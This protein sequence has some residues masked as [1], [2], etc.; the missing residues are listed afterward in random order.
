MTPHPKRS[1]CPRRS[2]FRAAALV[3]S[4]LM[5]SSC[6]AETYE[7]LLRQFIEAYRAGR[8]PDLPLAPDGDA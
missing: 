1:R 6:V 4:V 8:V 2:A 3:A 5:S 7:P